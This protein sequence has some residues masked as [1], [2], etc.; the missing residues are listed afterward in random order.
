MKDFQVKPLCIAIGFLTV[1]PI[2]L[3]WTLKP[4]DLGRSMAF[5]PLVGFI[6]GGI[7]VA[8]NLVLLLLFSRS[9]ADFVLILVLALVTGGLH[10]DGLADTCDGL[11]GGKTREE[12]LSIMKD[13][14]VGA[15][16]VVSLIFAIGVKYATLLSIPEYMK[17]AS[18]LV[19]PV[20]SRWS[21]AL[22]A[23]LSPYARSKGGTGRDFVESVSTPSI[24]TA[25]VLAGVISAW[26]L[27]LWGGLI[28]LSI[29]GITLLGVIYFRRRLGGVTGDIL[30][31][32]NEVTEALVLLSILLL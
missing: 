16:G 14:R 30:G 15:M 8:V 29:G 31:A 32:V 13:S 26:L 25:S 1:F 17:Y 6:I 2:P 12:T 28:M 9:V 5:F 7:L 4:E 20:I 23:Y 10:L 22:A 3:K 11:Y 24:L 21:M 19:M 27:G 18:L